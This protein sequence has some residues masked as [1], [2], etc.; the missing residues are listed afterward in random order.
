M[1]ATETK[2]SITIYRDGVWAG[3]GYVNKYGEV[4][5]S[6]VLGPDQDASD[7]TYEAICDAIDSEPQDE[8]RYTGEGS[9]TR[10]DGEY[11]W[12]IKN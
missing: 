10:P 3:N 9:V 4:E 2:L 12:E 11:A 6:A 8:G 7:A 1:N 5:C